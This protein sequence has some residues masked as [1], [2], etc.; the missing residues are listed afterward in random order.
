MNGS[1]GSIH[2][3]TPARTYEVRD[4]LRYPERTGFQL[5]PDG[6]HLAYLAVHAGRL[7]LFVQPLD[8]QGVPSGD[9]TVLTHETV[10]DM[11]GFCWKGSSHLLYLKDFGG[12]ENYHVVAVPIAGGEPLDLTPHEGIR[13]S[14]VDGL[15]DD[16]R[17]ILICHNQRDPQVFDVLRVDVTNGEATMIARNPGN[18]LGWMTDHAGRLRVAVASDGVD[19]TL[20][21]RDDETEP[22]RAVATTSFRETI[23]PLFFTF[24]DRRLYV[25]SNRG[26]DRI[27]IFE[28]DPR[29]GREGALVFE[30]D[31]VDLTGMSYSRRRRT[32]TTVWYADDRVRRHCL[33]DHTA[34]LHAGLEALLPDTEVNLASITRDESLAL[35]RTANDRS[36]GGT[37]IYHFASGRLTK[38][39]DLLPWL[40]PEDMAPMHAIAYPSR[41]GLTIHG[42]LTLP[43]GLAP[44]DDEAANLPLIVN[45]HGGPWARNHWGFNAEAQLLANRGYA[46]LQ[47]NFRGSTGY[48]RAFWEAG[49]GQWGRAMQND[50]DDGVDWLI[51]RGIVDPRRIG[52]YGVSYGGYATLAGIAFTP[53]RYAAAVDYVGVSNLFTLLESVPAYWKPT[54]EMM[55]EMI[56]DPRTEEGR[57]ALHDASPLF[58]AD[59]IV[60]PLFVAQGAN[61]PRV[62]RSDSDR[63]VEALR[64]RGVEVQYMLKDN[65]GHGFQNEENRLEFYEAMV[66]FFD[67]HLGPK[68]AA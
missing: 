60:T 26:R 45:P 66:A 5:A 39:A 67:A 34:H 11:L 33:D 7:N 31:E 9:A 49:F 53:E 15:I 21:Y 50:I 29:T 64:G 1:R 13:A 18:I 10:R 57:R 58:F 32:L 68:P 38:I 47:V 48:G 19:K 62:N 27:A 61:D 51:A 23:S 41:D 40:A 54:L 46:V 35:V 2:P 8:A 43:A 28:F 63:I 65:E 36:P 44:D 42:Y 12:D 17:H 25:L 24:D 22:F 52:I 14:I 3:A 59:R 16:D 56:G 30:H 55:Y 4:F 6:R 20:L 37:W